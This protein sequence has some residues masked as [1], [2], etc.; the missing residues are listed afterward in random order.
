M[1]IT[2]P[3]MGTGFDH[4]FEIRAI[5]RGGNKSKS[6][7]NSACV[8]FVPKI[9]TYNVITPNRPDYIDEYNEY[10]TIDN[11]EHYPESR[12]VILN[13]YGKTIFET[14]GYTNNWNGKADGNT[15]PSGTYFYELELNEPR[16]EIKIIKG[17]VSVLY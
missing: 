3:D 8:A 1:Q 17:F 13:R 6:I 14:I 12:L 9:K 2:Y 15:V 11:I 10:F 16:N 4:C 7:S 5:E